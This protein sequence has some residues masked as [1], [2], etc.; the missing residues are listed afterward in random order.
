MSN[1]KLQK[2]KGNMILKGEYDYKCSSNVML[3]RINQS[4]VGDDI[5][6][7]IKPNTIIYNIIM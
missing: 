3:D 5:N 2:Y 7:Y 4:N 6:I 1:E